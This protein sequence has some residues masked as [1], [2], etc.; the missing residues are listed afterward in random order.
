MKFDYY[1][2]KYI[3]SRNPLH[4]AI[5]WVGQRRSQKWRRMLRH[6]IRRYDSAIENVSNEI[7]NEH[8]HQAI[9]TLAF[10]LKA[11]S[12]E[13]ISQCPVFGSTFRRLLARLDWQE[14]ALRVIGE[15]CYENI[16][17]SENEDAN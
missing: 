9:A 4:T 8:F 14:I 3:L 5:I 11:I 15:A 16:F 10:Y 13:A 7:A 17:G 2:L 1:R 12:T 6:I